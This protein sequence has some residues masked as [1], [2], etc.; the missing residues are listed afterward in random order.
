MKVFTLGAQL[1]LGSELVDWYRDATS[2]PFDHLLVDLSLGRDDRLRYCTNS[3]WVPSKLY[4]PECLKQLRTL[5]DEPTNSLYSPSVLIGFPQIQK[6]LSSVL[7]TGVYPVS[8]HIFSK[9]TQR[10]LAGR[11]KRSGGQYS[12]RKLVFIAK[13]NN[14]ETE[15]KR[16]F[17]GKVI[18]SNKRHYTFRH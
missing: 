8:V 1:G 18:A 4:T 13:K 12:R 3:G 10:K 6:P 15:K 17:V 2:I 14:L 5:D 7:P 16:S 9:S 11:K